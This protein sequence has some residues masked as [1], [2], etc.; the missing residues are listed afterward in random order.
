M[1][2]RRTVLVFLATA[3][4]IAGSNLAL[5]QD[6]AG[7]D[8]AKPAIRRIQGDRVTL[9]LH[10][11]AS[12]EGVVKGRRA[13]VLEGRHY[14]PAT[15]PDERGAGIRVHYT[16]GLNGYIFIRYAEIKK[17]TFGSALTAEEGDRIARGVE[18]NRQR[19]AEERILVREELA[20]RKAARLAKERG[21]EEVPKEEV[22]KDGE[23]AEPA[24]VD[25]ERA[26]RIKDLLVKFPP[27][28]WKPDRIDELRR[29]ALI[30]DV[31][32]GPEEREFLSNYD[33]WL[34]GYL[35]W[36]EAGTGEGEKEDSSG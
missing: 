32:P 18:E 29:R 36:A 22:A 19:A 6:E 4:V 21:E 31:L 35:E 20:R 27:D 10:T 5:A 2:H 15:S 17:I 33:L 13:E 14:R 7:T 16:W 25:E 34:E 26:T 8:S 3:I 9:R 1:I 24:K 11:G 23:T 12:F 30:M 28:K